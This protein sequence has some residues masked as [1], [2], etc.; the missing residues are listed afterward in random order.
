VGQIENQDEK[1]IEEKAD[2]SSTNAHEISLK[3]TKADETLISFMMF[4]AMRVDALLS[5]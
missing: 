4:S 2:L 5:N 1:E 3:K